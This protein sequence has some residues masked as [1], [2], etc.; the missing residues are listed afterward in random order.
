MEIKEQWA[1]TLQRQQ[2]LPHCSKENIENIIE[3]PSGS[4]REIT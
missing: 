4:Y 3:K 2:P 1:I